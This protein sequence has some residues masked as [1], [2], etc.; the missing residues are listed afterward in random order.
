MVSVWRQGA[1]LKRGRYSLS[2]YS[3]SFYSL[4]SYRLRYCRVSSY[5]L[6]SI[7]ADQVGGPL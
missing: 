6:A 3:I 5:R 1:L 4:S 2:F 7:V